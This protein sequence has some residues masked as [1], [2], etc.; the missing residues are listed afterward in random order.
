MTKNERISVLE[1]RVDQLMK[2]LPSPELDQSIFDGHQDCWKYAAIDEDGDV[3]LFECL[4]HTTTYAN[5]GIWVNDPGGFKLTGKSTPTDN[6]RGSLIKRKEKEISGNVICTHLLS[7]NSRIVMCLV[8]DISEQNAI[9]EEILT[10]INSKHQKGF[11]CI[12]Q[13]SW[14]YVV[15]VNNMGEPLTAKDVGL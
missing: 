11:S 7:T 4:P 3:S 9:S 1:R 6:W 15:P 5:E 12:K 8:S 14:K 13:V 2:L 10:I